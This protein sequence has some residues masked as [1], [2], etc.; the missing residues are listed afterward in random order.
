M[1]R[2][3]VV[4][5]GGTKASHSARMLWIE[6]SIFLSGQ[7]RNLE[8]MIQ[9]I[10]VRRPSVA[11]DFS[12]AAERVDEVLFDPPEVVFGLRIGE[13]ENRARVGAGPKTCGTPY[14]SR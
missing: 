2:E 4:K 10:S 7:S 13:T 3:V 6:P 9:S 5:T 11:V 1:F 12:S 14:R 8:R